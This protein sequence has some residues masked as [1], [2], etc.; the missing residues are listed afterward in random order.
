MNRLHLSLHLS[1]HLN[2]HL[3][4]RPFIVLGAVGRMVPGRIPPLLGGV[5]RMVLDR[6]PPLLQ[7]IQVGFKVIGIHEQGWQ[8]GEAP[9]K[10]ALW[11]KM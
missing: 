11:C 4:N 1:L 6:I 9:P 10:P 8:R 2:R 3:L 5:G 7:T